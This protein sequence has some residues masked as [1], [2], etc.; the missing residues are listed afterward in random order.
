MPDARWTPAAAAAIGRG[1]QMRLGD[2]VRIETRVVDSIA[3]EA[4]GKHRYVVSRVDVAAVEEMKRAA[5]QAVAAATAAR[6][7]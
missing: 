1:L 2:D 7:P 5:V 4:S 6:A 3:P